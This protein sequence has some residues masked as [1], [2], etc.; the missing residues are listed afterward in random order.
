MRTFVKVDGPGW[1]PGTRYGLGVVGVPL[2]CGGLL[3][4]HG[5]DTPGHHSAP[6]H[7]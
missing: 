1:L 3:W 5:G 7:R 6:V 2:T 4:G